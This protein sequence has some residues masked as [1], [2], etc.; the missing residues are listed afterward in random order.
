MVNVDYEDDREFG[1]NGEYGKDLPKVCHEFKE[2]EKGG[3]MK[4]GDFNESGRIGQ[5]RIWQR[6]A[7]FQIR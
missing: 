6:V 3:P 4:S 5:W 7:K 2:M 1:A